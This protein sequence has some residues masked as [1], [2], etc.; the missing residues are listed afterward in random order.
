[1]AK[2]IVDMFSWNAPDNSLQ[3]LY[4]Y[5]LG[6]GDEDAGGGGGG[7]GGGITNAYYPQSTGGDNLQ[8]N[9]MPVLSAEDYGIDNVAIN[10]PYYMPNDPLDPMRLRGMEPKE[11]SLAKAIVGDR[12]LKTIRKSD[13]DEEVVPGMEWLTGKYDALPGYVKQYA[14]PTAI[15]AMNPIMGGALALNKFM[16]PD[17]TESAVG[18]GGLYASEANLAEDLLQAGL[19]TEGGKTVTG[20]NWV[21]LMGGYEE[22]Q[23]EIYD[24]F[25]SKYGGTDPETQDDEVEQYLKDYAEKHNISNWKK[26]FKYTQWKEAKFNKDRK[27]AMWENTKKNLAA[28]TATEPPVRH[29][30]DGDE[31][32]SDGPDYSDVTTKGPPSKISKQAAPISAP[33]PAHI[34]GRGGTDYQGGGQG[35]PSEGGAPTGTA[36]RNPWGR[37]KGGLIRKKYGNGG[38]VDLL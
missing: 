24:D 35:P 12:G 5:Y 21:S 19:L 4:E 32:P 6:G 28:Y 15:G 8:Y 3:A 20:K 31:P 18:I 14:L 33:V 10:N 27:D 13:D 38:I 22:G 37:A 25:I 1:M 34:I 16:R 9:E 36:G 26:S 17:A 7:G 23:Q 2:P 30:T 29:H 11:Y